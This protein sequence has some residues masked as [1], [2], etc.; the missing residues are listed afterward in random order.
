VAGGD[1]LIEEVRRLLV[2]GQISKFV[3][4]EQCARYDPGGTEFHLEGMR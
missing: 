3:T 4:D 2:E 1:N